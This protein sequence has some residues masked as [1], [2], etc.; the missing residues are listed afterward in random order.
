MPKIGEDLADE[1]PVILSN[2]TIGR[3]KSVYSVNWLL[4]KTLRMSKQRHGK[5]GGVYSTS[6]IHEHVL[7]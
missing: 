3:K 2:Q 5:G 1:L 4:G 7:Y 6:T